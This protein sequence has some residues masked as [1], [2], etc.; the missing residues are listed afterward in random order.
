MDRDGLISENDFI[1]F[2]GVVNPVE[3]ALKLGHLKRQVAECGERA[4]AIMLDTAPDAGGRAKQVL[5]QRRKLEASIADYEKRLAGHKRRDR[6]RVAEYNTVRLQLEALEQKREALQERVQMGSLTD[7]MCE[8]LTALSH[9]V[10]A[11]RLLL[12][13]A[14][15]ELERVVDQSVIQ[16]GLPLEAI[17]G[18]GGGSEDGGSEAGGSGSLSGRDSAVATPH[19]TTPL[20]GAGGGGGY[21]GEDGAISP[22]GRT[23][24]SRRRTILR[25]LAAVPLLRGLSA[26]ERVSIAKALVR[27]CSCDPC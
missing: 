1:T 2:L 21:P 5:R 19:A 10:A 27:P 8:D 16:K 7:E 24:Q 20:S 4:R 9:R 14:Q 11:H 13:D 12:Q 3:L 17:R 6:Q 18:G 23:K 22:A 26:G 25:F 15:L